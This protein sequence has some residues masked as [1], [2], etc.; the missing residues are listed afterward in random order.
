MF[1]NI[2]KLKE[3]SKSNNKKI[4]LIEVYKF[5]NLLWSTSA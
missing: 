3:N 5:Y 1:L 2:E 4:C